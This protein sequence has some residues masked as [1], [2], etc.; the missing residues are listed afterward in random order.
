[1][2]RGTNIALLPEVAS[3]TDR[4]ELL[5]SRRSLC[6]AR[7]SGLPSRRV[8]GA[9]QAATLIVMSAAAIARRGAHKAVKLTADDIAWLLVHIGHLAQTREIAGKPKARRSDPS[10]AVFTAG[11]MS[12]PTATSFPTRVWTDLIRVEL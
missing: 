8:T 3:E 11:H 4:R 12:R 10:T 2:G 1:L 7:E 9:L 5:L 6:V